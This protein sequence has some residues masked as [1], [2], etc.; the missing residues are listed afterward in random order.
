MKKIILIGFLLL[1]N[2]SNTACVNNK[3][4]VQE[5]NK[6][7]I[8]V[9]EAKKVLNDSNYVFIDVREPSEYEEGHIEGIKL[10]PLSNIPDYSTKLDKSKKYVAVCRSGARSKSATEKMQAL[11]LNVVN[12]SG[13]MNE[14]SEKGY[15]VTK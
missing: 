14:W 11:G 1:A 9:E 12:M 10:I 15:P 13:G 3:E 8:S 2:L 5:N 4:A 7:E 6:L